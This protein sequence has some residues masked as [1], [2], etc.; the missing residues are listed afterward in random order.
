MSDVA[1]QCFSLRGGAGIVGSYFF[2][3][4]LINFFTPGGAIHA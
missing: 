4:S 3:I 2:M 1:M